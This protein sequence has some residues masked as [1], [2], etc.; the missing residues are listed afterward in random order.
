MNRRSFL[1]LLSAVAPVAAVTPTYFF[2]PVGGWKSDVI[3]HPYSLSFGQRPLSNLDN[4]WHI[5]EYLSA[6]C[7]TAPM[8]M[9]IP[10]GW[11]SLARLIGVNGSWRPL[12]K[13]GSVAHQNDLT[14][15]IVPTSEH[16]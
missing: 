8:S 3:S 12:L 2:A 9:N 15:E 13:D 6:E 4:E 7:S 5:S 16:I 10:M 11:T 1:K 14:G